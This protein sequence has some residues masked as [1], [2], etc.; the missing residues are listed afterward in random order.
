VHYIA[1]RKVVDL[2]GGWGA[3]SRMEREIL[4]TAACFIST[5][6]RSRPVIE[7]DDF[8]PG[9]W[10]EFKATKPLPDNGFDVVIP[11]NAYVS[12]TPSLTSVSPRLRR[13]FEEFKELLAVEEIKLQHAQS[14]KPIAIQMFRWSHARK[15]AIRGRGLHYWQDLLDEARANGA[16]IIAP[17][18][19]PLAVTFDFALCI[20]TRCFDRCIFDDHYLPGGV[21]AESRRY[22]MELLSV[23]QALRP[24]AG[25]FSYIPDEHTYDVLW[26]YSVGAYV[27]GFFMRPEL[28]KSRQ[29]GGPPL[30]DF[31]KRFFS[32]RFGYL[33]AAN[34]QFTSFDD[35]SRFLSDHYLYCPRL[36]DES[37]K[38]LVS[39][40]AEDQLT[41]DDVLGGASVDAFVKA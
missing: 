24:V 29:L 9:H 4:T 1:M 33:T 35:V 5:G 12:P 8:D 31:A 25:D 11:A 36:Q 2:C 19:T 15:I 32:S 39:F 27:E 17:I 18:G 21:Y 30:P 14:K 7:I 40:G 34:L 6:K 38:K 3:F 20:A 26:I 22:H 13:F 28:E 16:P 41:L 23:M 37:L 10:H